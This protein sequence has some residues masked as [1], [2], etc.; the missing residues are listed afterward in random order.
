MSIFVLRLGSAKVGVR[1][2][3]DDFVRGSQVALN[4]VSKWIIPVAC[5]PQTWGLKVTRL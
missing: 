3:I 1:P 5:T 4:M 2:P